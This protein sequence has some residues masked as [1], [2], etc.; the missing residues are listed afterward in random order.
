[1]PENA[2]MAGLASFAQ[3]VNKGWM[4][5]GF[6]SS[7][8]SERLKGYYKN[9]HLFFVSI[10]DRT[11]IE[12]PIRGDFR[13]LLRTDRAGCRQGLVGRVGGTDLS[14]QETTASHR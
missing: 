2:L 5:I 1:L 7:H 12:L 10:F 13:K 3:V 9:A 4:L 11:A 6:D 14:P 8:D